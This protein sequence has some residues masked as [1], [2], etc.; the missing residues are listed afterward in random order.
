M[1]EVEEKYLLFLLSYCAFFVLLFC[2]SPS[3]LTLLFIIYTFCLFV[4]LHFS[5]SLWKSLEVEQLV[6]IS[7]KLDLLRKR[8]VSKA[9]NCCQYVE[10]SSTM[11]TLLL[12]KHC[13]RHNGP[14][15]WV[16]L[17][18]QMP[19]QLQ[20]TVNKPNPTCGQTMDNLISCV[21]IISCTLQ[22]N[23]RRLIGCRMLLARQGSVLGY[24][25]KVQI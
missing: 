6:Q 9:A 18:K 5:L 4:F 21:K 13:K 16:L 10:C 17:S 11:Q 20:Q 1:Q 3:F 19:E 25:G 22:L 24:S 12:R 23:N 14:E 2:L 15:G 8:R 7:T